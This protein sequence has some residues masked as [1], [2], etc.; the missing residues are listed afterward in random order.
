MMAYFFL[1][2]VHQIRSFGMCGLVCVFGWSV[3]CV[4]VAISIF[5]GEKMGEEEEGDSQVLAKFALSIFLLD[6]PFD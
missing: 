6:P 5:V 3:V 1:K 2:S 4:A